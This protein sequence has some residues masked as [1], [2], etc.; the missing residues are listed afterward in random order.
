MR[1]TTALAGAIVLASTAMAAAAPKTNF[2]KEFTA[3][4][5]VYCPD[6]A[7]GLYTLLQENP[8]TTTA[9]MI[10]GGD[11]YTTALG[12]QLINFYNLTGYPTVWLDG[13]ASQVGS[14]GSPAGN[15]ANLSNMLAGAASSTDVTI[16]VAGNE[17]TT[18]QYTL[19][20]TVAVENGGST[21]NMRIYTTQAYNQVNWPES[22]EIQ[23]N[24]LRQSAPTQDVTLSAGQSHTFSHTFTLTGESTNTEHVN[25]VVWAQQNANS[26]PAMI[27]QAKE[28]NH[29][30][31]PPADVTVGVDGDYTTIQAALDAVGSGST[32]T[33]DPGTYVEQLDFN[34][35]TINLVSASMDPLDTIIDADGEGTVLTMM[36]N[37]SGD[38]NGFTIRGGMNSSGS[39][40]RAA[41]SPTITNCI[42]RNN[43][44]TI[45]F[46]ILSAGD[47]YLAGNMFCSNDPNT[48]GGSWTDGGNN[49]FDDACEDEPCDGD[50]NG[51]GLVDV[52]DILHVLSGF[53]SDYDVNDILL[54]L[55]A[56]GDMC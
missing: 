53:G 19:D 46:V 48:I 21:R 12:N 55:S 32:V 10:H 13:T 26:A 1:S 54:V 22:N 14:Y 2:F 27:Y 20:I 29:G 40:I 15:Y 24:T 11:N 4:W 5:C 52:N 8:E 44:A 18:N 43:T 35:R 39:A 9:L 31:A 49:T 56:F 28:H 38:L 3:T 17:G 45:S 25:Y 23:F 50:F 16:D 37:A 51:D 36:G 34:G 41:G 30:E 47:A 6:V 42:F 33:V 7:E